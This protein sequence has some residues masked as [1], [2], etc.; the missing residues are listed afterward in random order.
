[1]LL[2]IGIGLGIASIIYLA[3]NG[4]NVLPVII[5]FGFSYMLYSIMSSNNLIKSPQK[6]ITNEQGITFDQ[7]G[8]QEVAKNELIEALNFIKNFDEAKK[9]GHSPPQ[10]NIANGSTWYRQ[11]SYG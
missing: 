5:M 4:I 3:I 8:G 9:D 11:N 7:I 6:L 1:L 2:E 10:R